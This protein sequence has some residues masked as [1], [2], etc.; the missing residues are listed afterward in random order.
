MSNL[1]AKV[2]DELGFNAHIKYMRDN[3]LLQ[4][5]VDINFLKS[6][7]VILGQVIQKA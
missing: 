2:V 3:S 7:K 6:P 4:R 1:F 5:S